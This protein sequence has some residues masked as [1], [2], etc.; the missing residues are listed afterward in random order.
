VGSKEDRRKK[1]RLTAT[2]YG[3]WLTNFMHTH[4]LK[5]SQLS[6][7]S[8]FHPNVILNWRRG[9][10][11]PNGYSFV[12]MATALSRLTGIERSILFE[13]MAEALLRS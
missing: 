9:H 5:P 13:K 3:N 6:T 1:E 4:Q 8:G 7:V 10:C 11:L 12:V 2:A